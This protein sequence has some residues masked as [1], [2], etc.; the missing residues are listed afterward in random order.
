M[1]VQSV[2]RKPQRFGVLVDDFAARA[3][4]TDFI[5]GFVD[6]LVRAA[7]GR[8]VVLIYRTQPPLWLWRS[9]ARRLKALMFGNRPRNIPD[10]RVLHATLLDA[11]LS[12]LPILTVP[13]DEGALQ[14]LCRRE[15]IDVI[16]PF[17][18]PPYGTIQ[19]PWLGY[20][21]DFQHRHLPHLFTAG[22]IA[23]RDNLFRRILQKADGIVVNATD[24]LHDCARFLPG[25][26]RKV[27]ALPFS[28]APKPEW[29]DTDPE[30]ARRKYSLGSRYFM[31]SNQFW[32]HKRH[33]VAI[34]AF[35]VVAECEPGLELVLTGATDDPRAPTRLADIEALIDSLGM[36]GRVHILGLIPKLDQIAIMRGALA[37]VQPTAFEGGPGGGAVFDAVAL[38]V[39]TLVSSIPVNREIEP[40]VTHYFPLDDVNALADAMCAILSKGRCLPDEQLLKVAGAERRKAMG[41]AIWHAAELAM[42]NVRSGRTRTG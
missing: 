36:T 26:E 15:A 2:V 10:W 22:E 6:G 25:L 29:M 41:Q 37:V 14:Q 31:V 30:A 27:V 33:E 38:G 18:D 28:A 9:A 13:R 11:G 21:Y 5:V 4:V 24:V 17:A 23:S 7:G 34:E 42:D 3:G 40:L 20:I 16:G 12:D 35:A 1:T 19:V 32:L 8:E 39:P